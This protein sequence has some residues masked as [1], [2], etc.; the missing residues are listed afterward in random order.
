[1]NEAQ[2]KKMRQFYHSL[3]GQQRVL[4]QITHAAVPH[5]IVV[6]LISELEELEKEFPRLLPKLD[7]KDFFSYKSGTGTPYYYTD[8]IRALL[9]TILGRLQVLIEETDSIPVTERK[10]F[11]FIQSPELRKVIERDFSEVQRAYIAECWKSVIILCGGTIEAIL[12]DLLLA[13]GAR[14]KSSG[15]A[16]GR[17]S[18]ITKWDLT[19][20][21]SVAVDLK[22]ISAG[23]EKLSHSLREYRNLVHPGNEIRNKLTFDAEEARIAL[24]VLNIVY[25]D[26]SK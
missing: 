14:A 16:P 21:I 2:L 18:D 23:V 24:E 25:R 4:N 17:I 15:A 11:T 7:V 9:A 8:G 3:L 20:L 1:V 5:H 22:L 12:T 26:L 19:D 13:N 10:A 6:V